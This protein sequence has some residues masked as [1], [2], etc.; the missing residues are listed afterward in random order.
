MLKILKNNRTIDLSKINYIYELGNERSIDVFYS[1]IIYILSSEESLT[2][3]M[4][5]NSVFKFLDKD[6]LNSVETESINDILYINID[7]VKCNEITS[8]GENINDSYLHSIYLY[9][10]SED[11]A[12]YILEINIDGESLFSLTST[13]HPIH[14]EYET[15]LRNIGK[16]FPHDITKAVWDGDITDEA[17]DY[18]LLNRKYKELLLCAVD[19][20]HRKGSWKA[21]EDSFNWFEWGDVAKLREYWNNGGDTLTYRDFCTEYSLLIDDNTRNKSKSTYLSI[22]SPMY[23]E[24]GS[25]WSEFTKSQSGEVWAEPVDQIQYKGYDIDETLLKL[26]I[27]LLGNYFSSFFIPIHMDL[28][29]STIE[30]QCRPTVT[31]K[32]TSTHSRDE[33]ILVNNMFDWE[34]DVENGGIFTIN[35]V[36]CSTNMDTNASAHMDNDIIID[37]DG[38][39][40]FMQIG[41]TDIENVSTKEDGVNLYEVIENYY[42]GMGSIVPITINTAA[43]RPYQ[44]DV[45]VAYEGF[46]NDIVYTQ[47]D[48]NENGE[49]DDVVYVD[50]SYV[51]N[52]AEGVDSLSAT[53]R[54]NNIF[55]RKTL[56]VWWTENDLG[57]DQ[58]DITA[59]L[60]IL[61][62][63]VGTYK[64]WLKPIGSTVN[65]GWKLINIYINKPESQGLKVSSIKEKDIYYDY[66]T[67]RMW[68]GNKYIY[69]SHYFKGNDDYT[70]TFKNVDHRHY[71]LLMNTS[72]TDNRSTVFNI[73]DDNVSN[74]TIHIKLLKQNDGYKVPYKFYWSDGE[75]SSEITNMT[76][77]FNTQLSVSMEDILYKLNNYGYTPDYVCTSPNMTER[78]TNRFC[79]YMWWFKEFDE[80][81]EDGVI[82]NEQQSFLIGMRIKKNNIVSSDYPI[83]YASETSFSVP[84]TYSTDN[85]FYKNTYQPLMWESGEY[86]RTFSQDEVIRIDPIH[87]KLFAHD[88]NVSYILKNNSNG[89]EITIEALSHPLINTSRLGR[90]IWDI[91]YNYKIETTGG[92]IEDTYELK[93]AFKVE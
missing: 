44:V 26:K 7:D 56:Q 39:T 17:T 74:Q 22:Y 25:D 76:D 46:N 14:E 75:N 36:E 28:L 79:Q 93:N 35:S 9:S 20:F 83:I 6:K 59:K 2:F 78:L 45:V 63:K 4:E 87:Y 30:Y 12:E 72:E 3:S 24:T 40:E 23:E 62:K 57:S 11:A 31:M 65:Y 51:Y 80:V 18:I 54:I 53:N 1:D 91:I 29:S 48:L 37:N 38:N 58:D 13:F 27:V 33:H 10:C 88:D 66:I 64:I 15:L 84:Q 50:S 77:I 61:F 16:R 85:I 67:N 21:I 8:K 92:W 70:V 82:V 43:D 52:F 42:S 5:D 34:V 68:D 89:S 55:Y 81:V 60:N 69:K 90:G 41:V 19:I 32:Y 86:N 47:E 73:K 71:N 49:V